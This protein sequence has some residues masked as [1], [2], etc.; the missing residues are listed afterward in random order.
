MANTISALRT[1]LNSLGGKKL[2]TVSPE[3][4]VVYQAVGVPDPDTGSGYNNY[5]VPIAQL[6]DQYIDYYQPQ[7]YNNWYEFPSGSLEYLQD[8]YLNWRNLQGMTP[9][10]CSPIPNWAGIAG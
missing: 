10:G 5:L 8:V 3:C 6:A 2:I 4:V 1:K 7:A 9:W